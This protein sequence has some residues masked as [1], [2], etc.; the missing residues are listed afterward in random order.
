MLISICVFLCH[1]LYV[2]SLGV[3]PE[4][5]FTLVIFILANAELL[6]LVNVCACIV[7]GTD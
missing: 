7:Q 4:T 3:L 2:F 1:Y 6:Q 5:G